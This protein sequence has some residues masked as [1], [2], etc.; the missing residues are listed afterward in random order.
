VALRL[1]EHSFWNDNP[2]WDGKAAA[3]R[4]APRVRSGG[5]T[6]REWPDVVVLSIMLNLVLWHSLFV[7]GR[8]LDLA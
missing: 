8:R 6:Y 7:E 3:L 2:F 4:L 1:F 5:W